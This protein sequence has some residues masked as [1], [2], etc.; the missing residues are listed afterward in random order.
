MGSLE[1]R[2]EMLENKSKYYDK[3]MAEIG[4]LVLSLSKGVQILT[5]MQ[6]QEVVVF[7]KSYRDIMKKLKKDAD[8]ALNL[9][10]GP[11]NLNDV[12]LE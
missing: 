1:E 11:M 12:E 5:S 6:E 10:F 4:Q 9:D 3:Y 2:I 7:K 8:L